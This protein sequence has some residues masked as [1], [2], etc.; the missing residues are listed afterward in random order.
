MAISAINSVF[1]MSGKN[2]PA[3]VAGSFYPS[4]KEDLTSTL[5]QYFAA[6][7]NKGSDNV[8][9]VILPHAGYVF[10]GAM[11]AKGVATISPDKEYDRVIL[12]GPSHRA[13][14]DGA[15]VCG[16]YDTYTTPLGKVPVD[17]DVCCD[18]VRSE[19]VF[20]YVPSAHMREH[21]LEVEIPF[22]QY[23]L[24]KMPPI[25]PILI[26][27]ES[28]DKIKRIAKT[29]EP[30]FN[31]KT[32]FVISSDFSHYP[33]YSDA[34]EVDKV[35]GDS[36][37]SGS[38]DRFV[39]AIAGNS[40]KHIP[41]LL[42]STCGHS[43]IA[44]LLL[45]MQGKSDAKIHH[46]GYCNSGD[47]SYGEHNEVVGYHAFN[48]T[49]EKSN[50]KDNFSLSDKEKNLLLKAAR[51]SI[52]NKLNHTN[53]PPI[54][55]DELTDTLKLHCGA[56]VTLREHGQ[57]RGCIGHLTS[58]QP[59]YKLVEEMAQAAAFDD[60]RFYPVTE[61]ELKDLHIDISVLSP[62]KKI[63]SI[64]DI[65]LGKHG[66]YIV[67]DGHSGTFLPQVADET[68]WTKAEFLGHCSKD[69][70]GIGW[71]GWREADIYI[72]EADVFEEK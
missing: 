58:S 16:E 71:D 64:D 8:Q 42:T 17:K 14:F 33:S 15:S 69:K 61:K 55:A 28:I 40:K 66:I 29:L 31:E 65:I 32:L 20:G 68:N 26:G 35:T 60:P 67:K 39:S 54:S 63:S 48:V 5:E 13:S 38:I 12:I 10:S 51:K 44:V 56:F 21:C 25:V 72:Y 47:S 45:M 43:P 50:G 18:L 11:A 57:L 2:R 62:L 27:T 22:L 49:R 52:T 53:E 59:L 4:N 3:A 37:S 36:I 23:R 34:L 1:P 70:A 19:S 30:Y 6:E 9:A 41:N 24:K 7:N 46:L